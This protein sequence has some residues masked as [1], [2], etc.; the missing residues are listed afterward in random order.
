VLVVVST[1][2]GIPGLLPFSNPMIAAVDKLNFLTFTTP[3]RALA[4]FPVA[5]DLPI[6]R[7]L[8]AAAVAQAFH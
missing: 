3:I 2:L 1:G 4:G 8:G 7:Q 5:K 6:F